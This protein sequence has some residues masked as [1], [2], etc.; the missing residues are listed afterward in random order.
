MRGQ[1]IWSELAVAAILATK[2]ALQL[3]KVANSVKVGHALSELLDSAKHFV[4]PL[5]ELVPFA[6]SGQ[7]CLLWPSRRV[8]D[9]KI[10]VGG[11]QN[12]LDG[13]GGRGGKLCVCAYT[14]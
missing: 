2:V 12:G 13:I 1:L 8:M 4:L 5:P 10:A 11:D 7:S 9:R 14:G 6:G 3:S